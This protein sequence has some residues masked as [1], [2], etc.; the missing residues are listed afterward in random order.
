MLTSRRVFSGD[1]R[2]G[3][4]GCRY[5]QLDDTNLAYLCD[6]KLRERG[7]PARRR[8]RLLPRRYATLINA[9]IADR[10]AE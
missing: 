3:A 10:P 8:P 9:A 5:L 7:A 1:R 4:A 2:L 6:A